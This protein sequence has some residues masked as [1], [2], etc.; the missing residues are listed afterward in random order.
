[1]LLEGPLDR[2]RRV[3]EGV[4]EDGSSLLLTGQA[5]FPGRAPRRSEVAGAAHV[6]NQVVVVRALPVVW[7]AR[8][9]RPKKNSRPKDGCSSL[10]VLAYCR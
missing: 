2:D 5:R 4:A 1:M 10:E 7:G 8:T 6:T 3:G 9:L